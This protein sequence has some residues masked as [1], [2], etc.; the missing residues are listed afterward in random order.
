MLAICE[1]CAKKYTID[2]SRI[3]GEKAR[4]SC[5]ECGHIIVVT[6]PK[7]VELPPDAPEAPEEP[8][9]KTMTDEEAMAFIAAMDSPGGQQDNNSSTSAAKGGFSNSIL[10]V[11]LITGILVTCGII[12]Y[13]YLQ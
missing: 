12:A 7:A 8:E 2:E 3:K 4:F 10:T 11:T 1:D 5:Y 6:K 13:M 9:L